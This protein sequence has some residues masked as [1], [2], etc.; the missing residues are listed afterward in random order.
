MLAVLKLDPRAYE[1][2]SLG[3]HNSHCP[4]AFLRYRNTKT[5]S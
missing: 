4:D 2:S 5:F 3:A 1:A